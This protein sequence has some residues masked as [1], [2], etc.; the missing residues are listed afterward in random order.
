MSFKIKGLDDLQKRLKSL[1]ETEQISL[2]ELLSPAF[3]SSC[4]RFANAQELFDASGFQIN[5]AD[6]FA[7]IPD[8]EWDKF[9]SVN[10][11]FPDWISMQKK[12][13][14]KWMAS[15]LQG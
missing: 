1:S 4:S 2:A 8:A 13:H 5:S 12:A 7:S 3:L 10:T 9:I 11:T 6:D 15:K 14:E